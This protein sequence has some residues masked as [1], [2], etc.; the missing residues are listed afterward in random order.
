ME[1]IKIEREKMAKLLG[2][3]SWEDVDELNWGNFADAGEYAYTE[4]F[5]EFSCEGDEVA[6]EKAEEARESGSTVAANEM[7]S[8]Y[9]SACDRAFEVYL[10]YHG[11]EFTAAEGEAWMLEITPLESWEKSAACVRETI[12]GVGMFGY[13]SLEDFIGSSSCEDARDVVESHLH[14]LK[15]Y[16]EVYGNDSPIRIYERSFR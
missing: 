15:R 6:Q 2:L 10:R 11:M 14:W 16:G 12:E 1:S 3:P 13:D 8:S 4:A 9:E 5:K 7:Y